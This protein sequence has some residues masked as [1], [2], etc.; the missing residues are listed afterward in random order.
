MVF[1]DNRLFYLPPHRATRIWKSYSLD[2]SSTKLQFQDNFS[3][4]R[5]TEIDT[6]L[7]WSWRISANRQPEDASSQRAGTE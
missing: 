7:A 5:S 2:I 6:N 3:Q 4:F 1:L